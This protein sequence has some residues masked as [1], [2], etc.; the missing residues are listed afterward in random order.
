VSG[1]STSDW[2]IY[3]RAL[4]EARPRAGMIGLYFAIGL[5]A[6]PLSVLTP[7]PLK[8]V[9]DSVLGDEP[10]PGALQ[11]LPSDAVLGFA[12]VLLVGVAL[13]KEIQSRGSELT[14]TYVS[15]MLVLGF[16]ARILRHAQRLSV[17]HH[18]TAGTADATYRIMWDASAISSIAIDGLIPIVIASIT[19]AS[20]LAIIWAIDPELGLVAIA[21]AP[22]LLVSARRYRSIVRPRYRHAKQVESS[23]LA[24]V[25][26]QL[27]SL[28]VVKAFGQEE[29]EHGKFMTRASEGVRTRMRIAL[30]EGIFGLLNKGIVAAGTAGVLYLGAMH[31]QAGVITLGDLLLI[32]GYVALLYDPI[33]T[34]ASRIA[35]MQ[36]SLASAERAFTLLDEQPDVR[37]SPDAIPLRRATGRVAFD[38]V[39]YRYGD[40]ALALEDLSFEVPAGS[41]VGVLGA[42]GAGKTTLLSLLTR[43]ADPVHGRILLDGYD[44]RDYR[45]ADLRN[46]FG[47]VLQEPVLFS[48]TIAENIAYARDDASR[49]EIVEAARMA[50][51][52]DFI[53]A[54]P[55]G[56]ETM[57]G[58]R[59]MSLSGGERQRISIARAFLK[60][61]PILILDEP[62]SSVDVTTEASILEAIDLL[63]EGRT[64]FL[65]THRRAATRD[66][67][68]WLQLDRGRLVRR[69]VA[70]K[71]KPAPSSPVP[72]RVAAVGRGDA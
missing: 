6:S 27:T 53:T 23:A 7:V 20:M 56:Y 65:I 15:E 24:A 66:C 50:S 62:T 1:R 31:V 19:A 52:H 49:E 9:A 12:A 14:R 13:L 41:R 18:D 68:I 28:R 25:Q 55:R 43:F 35:R 36:S 2:A 30:S 46:Q 3:R 22:I 39:S 17:V 40:G 54:L 42:T 21:I 72:R 64:S 60:D 11:G 38:H 47:I 71:P 63:L 59:G 44:L 32:L 70:R 16:R 48:T 57:V 45:V 58:E 37:E 67:D 34:I 61:A 29:R 4:G 10:L 33:N 5:L 69:R 26:E 8:I 51:A